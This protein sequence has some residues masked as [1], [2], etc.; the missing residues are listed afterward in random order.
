MIICFG[1]IFFNFIKCESKTEKSNCAMTQNKANAEPRFRRESH[2][3]GT[4]LSFFATMTQVNHKSQL[5]SQPYA[6]AGE[7]SAP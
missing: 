3:S 6:V 5:I 2:D 1:G 4:S 7:G